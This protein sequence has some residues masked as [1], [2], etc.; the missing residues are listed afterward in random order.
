MVF[1][2]SSGTRVA[3]V[4]LAVTLFATASLKLWHFVLVGDWEVVLPVLQN[5]AVMSSLVVVEYLIGVAMLTPG[6]RL[7]AW[8]VAVIA[9]TGAAVV[10]W[11]A[12]FDETARSCGCLGRLPLT[13][14]EH[15]LLSAA[16]LALAAIVILG[17]QHTSPVPPEDPR[18]S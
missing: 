1:S 17:S 15:S 6:A 7:A 18:G 4:L 10:A 9:T 8:C 16:T 14:A 11:H 2:M 3:R 5:R 13:P 12:Q